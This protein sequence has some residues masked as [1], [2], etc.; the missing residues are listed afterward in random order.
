MRTRFAWALGIAAVALAC[1][2][3]LQ[4]HQAATETSPGAVPVA[5]ND[6]IEMAPGHAGMRVSIDPDTGELGMP[7]PEQQKAMDDDLREMLS[8]SADGLQPEVLPDGSV[9]VDLQG[10]FQSVSV[11][12]IDAAGQLHTGCIENHTALEGALDHETCDPKT[13]GTPEVK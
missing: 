2:S 13:S 4:L 9:R 11:A 1:V 5:G 8:R 10:R 12:S 3:T 6:G 7:T